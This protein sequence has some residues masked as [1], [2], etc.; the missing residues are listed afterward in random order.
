MGQLGNDYV[1][2]GAGI[3]SLAYTDAT[4]AVTLDLAITTA[5]NTGAYGIDTVINVENVTSGSQNDRLLGNAVANSL[6]TGDGADYIDGRAGNDQINGGNGADTLLGGAGNDIFTTEGDVAGNDVVDGG[7]GIDT[8]DYT[9][10]NLAAGAAGVKVDLRLLSAQ[11]T[12]AAGI[13]TISN[14][15]NLIGS[16]RNDMLNGS[17]SANNLNG[18]AGSD[19]VLGNGGNDVVNGFTGSDIVHGGAGNDVVDGGMTGAIGEIDLLY[20]GTGADRFFFETLGSSWTGSN[21]QIMDFSAAEGD[22]IDVHGVF[23]NGGF[24][25]GM[26]GTFIGDGAF[27]GVAGQLQVLKTFAGQL[28]NIDWDGNGAADFTV[29]VASTVTLQASDFIL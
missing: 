26:V 17:E 5:Q 6:S 16:I 22:K 12:D 11:N 20:G 29:A 19:T 28:V 23:T 3:D 1:D 8:I 10:V 9:F 15:E 18:G 27:T 7:L 4:G 24:P 2:G 25:I 14:V 13:D 21:D